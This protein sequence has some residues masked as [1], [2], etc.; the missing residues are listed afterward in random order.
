[1]SRPVHFEIQADDVERNVL[2]ADGR[3]AMPEYAMPGM[4]WQAYYL[5]PEGNT[6]GLHQADPS[7]A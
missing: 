1:M 2:D 4:A 6:S 7:A 5:T 3:V